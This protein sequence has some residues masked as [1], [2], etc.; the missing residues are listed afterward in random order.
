MGRSSGTDLRMRASGKSKTR[1]RTVG[2]ARREGPRTCA[3]GARDDFGTP[4]RGRALRLNVART[5]VEPGSALEIATKYKS[6]R[7]IKYR[8]QVRLV[9]K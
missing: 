6:I 9:W 1:G 4:L 7:F 3:P 5:T 2:L 8:V